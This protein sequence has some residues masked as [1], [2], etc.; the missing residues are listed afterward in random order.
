[1]ELNPAG[2]PPDRHKPMEVAKLTPDEV[3]A[4]MERGE[5]FIFID[6]RSSAEWSATDRVLPGAIHVPADEV[7]RHVK[8]IPLGRPLVSYCSSPH[9]ECS[10]RVARELTRRGFLNAHPLIGGLD[11]WCKAGYPVEH[12]NTA[13]PDGRP[14]ENAPSNFRAHS[15]VRRCAG[16]FA[17]RDVT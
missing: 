2:P 6:A 16:G 15:E 8:E 13:R 3:I 14:S 5:Q 1:M 10:D 11:A 9:E 12:K 17:K 7:S 4:R